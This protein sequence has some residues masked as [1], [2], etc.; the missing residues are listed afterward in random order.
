MSSRIPTVWLVASLTTWLIVAGGCAS[1]R[2]VRGTFAFPDLRTFSVRV[3][4]ARSQTPVA[5]GAD[6]PW[7]L[8]ANGHEYPMDAGETV[9]V[10]IEGSSLEANRETG[11]RISTEAGIE[12]VPHNLERGVFLAGRRYRGSGSILPKTGGLSVVNAVNIEDYLRGVLP[13][14]IGFLPATE[15]EAAKAQAVAARTYTLANL[16]KHR[17]HGYDLESTTADQVYRGLSEESEVAN[18]AIEATVSQVLVKDGML[19]Q[20]FYHSTCG[21]H[22]ESPLYVW[23]RS[24]EPEL[25]GVDDRGF[26]SWARSYSWSASWTVGELSERR[27]AWERAGHE[28]GSGAVLDVVVRGR[29]PSGRVDRLLVS[30]EGGAFE[31]RRDRVRRFLTRTDVPGAILQS[32]LFT[33]QA[34]RDDDGRL[35]QLRAIGRGFGH[36]AGMCQTGAIG[37][38]RKGYTYRRILAHYYPGSHL[39]EHR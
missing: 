13:H 9:S 11:E 19:V 6:G 12:I 18:R 8:L 5:I 33:L 37:M 32:T 28:A 20:A 14:E 4:V 23:D 25:S 15:I 17:E 39:E 24:V 10:R 31:V 36:G 16:D 27:A 34:T 26:C 35:A 1:R 21:G 22:T 38:A 7:S 2:A 29:T 3:L 30:T